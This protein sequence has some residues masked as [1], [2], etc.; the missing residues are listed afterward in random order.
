MILNNIEDHTYIRDIVSD[1]NED[2]DYE[3]YDECIEGTKSMPPKVVLNLIVAV[4][5]KNFSNVI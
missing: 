5:C 4:G 3:I 2:E 1:F